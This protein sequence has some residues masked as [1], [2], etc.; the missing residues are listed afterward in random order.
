MLSDFLLPPLLRSPGTP[1]A[2][3]LPFFAYGDS[4]HLIAS[5]AYA[6]RVFNSLTLLVHAPCRNSLS[7]I[8]N[9]ILLLSIIFFY[10]FFAPLKFSS[11]WAW[12]SGL[13][14]LIFLISQTEK[15]KHIFFAERICVCSSIH[16]KWKMKTKEELGNSIKTVQHTKHIQ[17]GKIVCILMTHSK[18]L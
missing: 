18:C 4:L 8:P 12:R 13:T 3:L 2:P 9:I 6:E 17:G 5:A 15:L 7:F 1:E 10:F 11:T 16:V 14:Y